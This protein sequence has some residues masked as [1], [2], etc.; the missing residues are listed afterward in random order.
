MQWLDSDGQKRI[1]AKIAKPEWEEVMSKETMLECDVCVV[2]VGSGGFGAA[3]AAARKGA[4]VIA[5][6]R[7]Q[8]VGGTTTMAW[9]H[10]WEPVS[11][12]EGIPGE[13]WNRMSAMPLATNG[14]PYEKGQPGY[15]NPQGSGEPLV[16]EPWAFDWCAQEMLR[17]AGNCRLLLGAPF[18]GVEASQGEVHAVRV[19]HH[20]EALVIRAKQFID[21][22]ADA[23]LCLRAGCETRVGEDTFAMY[24]ESLAP[25]EAK[26]KLNAM[27]LM[28][29]IHDTGIEQRPWLPPDTPANYCIEGTAM[30][31]LSN[32]D[33]LINRCGMLEGDPLDAGSLP[34]LLREAR[35]RVYA[36][37]Y[38][39]QM[40]KGYGTWSL[41]G[42]APE[43]GVRESRRVVGEY[44]LSQIDVEAGV[45]RQD[46]PDIIAICDHTLDMHGSGHFDLR[47]SHAPWG[48]PFRCLVPRNLDN[49]LVASRAASF[50]HI[51][52]TGNRLSRTIMKLGEA[53]GTAA[54]MAVAEKDAPKCLNMEALKAEL[55]KQ[56]R[57]EW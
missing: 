52:A 54:A 4:K 19:L 17:E 3:L 22:T 31:E 11:G 26:P 53:A 28:Y 48:I 27:T 8:V 16:F 9:V 1:H 45:S 35:R 24:A 21:A 42:I 29:R 20:G 47:V 51:A 12:A 57:G 13:L 5:V 41:I 40:Q 44:V 36:H 50:S 7:N 23:E 55:A 43:I 30:R 15:S 56:A 6:E 10:T 49:L 38:W 33:Q 34:D 2:G 32:G 14:K 39:L 25:V 37:F 18:V 46:H